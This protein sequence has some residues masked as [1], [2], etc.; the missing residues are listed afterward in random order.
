MGVLLYR[1]PTRALLG[2]G[3][4]INA[5]ALLVWGVS[6]SVGLPVGPGEGGP[7]P[8]GL[9]DSGVVAAE[10]AMVLGFAL[11]L[12]CPRRAVRISPWTRGIAIVVFRFAGAGL[13][14]AGAQRH[15]APGI[16][17]AH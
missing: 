5:G 10:L 17:H 16:E 14:T 3:A 15:S 1:R 6:R 11:T 7:E 8:V 2:G 12:R 9:A 4:L 13:P